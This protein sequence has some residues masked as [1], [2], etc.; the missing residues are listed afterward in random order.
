M[1]NT[2]QPL[3]KLLDREMSRKEFLAFGAFAVATAF[4]ITGLIKE[5]LSHAATPTAS[6]EVENGTVSSAASRVTDGTASGG[7]AVKFGSGSSGGGSTI[8][9]GSQLTTSNVGFT[10][11]TDSTL[12]RKLVQSD[13]TRITG[14]H[15]ISD[16]TGG[17][18]GTQ[19]NPL[20]VS[21][22]DIDKVVWDVDWVTLRGSRVRTIAN[23]D[24]T[25]SNRVGAF[26]DYV[27][28]DETNSPQEYCMGSQS[29]SMNRCL[30]QGN[31]DGIR[32]DGGSVPQIITECLFYVKA[33]SIADHNDNAQNVGGSGSVS[34]Q[35][36]MFHQDP[37]NGLVQGSS[38]IQSADM[39]SSSNYYLEV[40]DSMIYG[41]SNADEEALRLYD[42][43]LTH[44][45]TYKVTGCIWDHTA[46][47]PPM[48]RGTSNTTPVSQITWSNNKY[49]NGTAIS[50]S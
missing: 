35:R 36:C 50:L 18:G 5:L 3:Q 42:G 4:G 7:Q 26:L 43:G 34:F 49:D 30:I 14:S 47:S 8:T 20:V 1:S 39:S 15:W 32:V 44:N 9:H 41:G 6:L 16:F 33:A 28:F 45:I 37:T 10:A 31:S 40:I 38:V 17:K 2:K 23:E 13:L 25:G 22:L 12:G 48:G 24:S 27:T 29:F 19:A 11:Y 46:A 21:K